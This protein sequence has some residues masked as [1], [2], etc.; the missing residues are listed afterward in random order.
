MKVSRKKHGVRNKIKKIAGINRA[1]PLQYKPLATLLLCVYG[2]FV[3]K[4]YLSYFTFCP[5]GQVLHR[6]NNLVTHLR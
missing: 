2:T 6:K 4:L 3:L 5:L 1:S